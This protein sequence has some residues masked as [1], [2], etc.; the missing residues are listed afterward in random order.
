MPRAAGDVPGVADAR[1]RLPHGADAGDPRSSCASCWAG[2]PD[3]VG[4]RRHAAG[5]HPHRRCWALALGLVFSVRQRVH[6]RL[7]ARWSRRSPSS[8]TFS[9]PMMYPYTLVQVRF[10][11]LHRDVL[12]VQPDGRGGAAVPAR[13]LDRH[14]QRPRR[15]RGPAPARPPLHPGLIMTLIALVCVVLAAAA[16]LPGSSLV[17]RSG[18]AGARPETAAFTR[19]ALQ[20]TFPAGDSA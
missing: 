6:A 20:P 2:L 10:G 1:G 4:R 12:P 17:C 18:S 14:D 3:P 16:V 8:C 9:V 11:E 15:H 7:R 19:C 13:L 5:L